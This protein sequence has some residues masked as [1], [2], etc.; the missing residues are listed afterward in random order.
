MLI[1]RTLDEISESHIP[2][3]SADDSPG[4]DDISGILHDTGR[5]RIE[6][7][8]GSATIVDPWHGIQ[9]SW[10]NERVRLRR[11]GDAKTVRVVLLEGSV[12]LET[13]ME[14]NLLVCLHPD[15]QPRIVP[16]ISLLA[17]GNIS[18]LVGRLEFRRLEGRAVS[19]PSAPAQ[20]IGLPEMHSRGGILIG[21][22]PT[23]LPYAPVG[24]LAQLSVFDPNVQT[25]YDDV[26]EWDSIP[27][28]FRRTRQISACGERPDSNTPRERAHWYQHLVT[29]TGGQAMSATTR[30]A[31]HWCYAFLQHCS[32]Q[33]RPINR[34]RGSG[35]IHDPYY[36]RGPLFERLGRW[37]HRCFGYGYR[38]SRPFLSWIV[39]AIGVTAWSIISTNGCTG[40]ADYLVRFAAV[41]L[42]PLRFLRLGSE[43]GESLV[44]PEGL[45]ALAQLIV[46]VPF[47]FFIV[48]LREFFRSPL[49][50]LRKGP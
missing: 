29:A 39:V 6:Y 35:R 3:F 23:H 33:Q 37:V 34:I 36:V 9:L 40:G 13:D 17:R 41:L 15:W 28:C 38:P 42:S 18:N 24:W 20:V 30:A 4:I 19:A 2:T 11:E 1:Q 48:S 7:P 46:G 44:E 31:I 16:R 45:Q 5:M 32:I 8:N 47:I 21:I 26:L 25:L 49:S 12:E 50:R 22:D 27:E 14:I 10:S 43:S